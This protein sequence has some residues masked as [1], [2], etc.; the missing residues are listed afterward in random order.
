MD[1]K[2]KRVFVFIKEY[3]PNTDIG[4]VYVAGD[5]NIIDVL[6]G[7]ITSN[8]LLDIST[9]YW[10]S[11]LSSYGFKVHVMDLK[12][13]GCQRI[14]VTY[15]DKS[16]VVHYYAGKYYFNNV[17]TYKWLSTRLYQFYGEFDVSQFD[18]P[19]TAQ[20]RVPVS[21]TRLFDVVWCHMAACDINYITGKR[22]CYPT[23]EAHALSDDHIQVNLKIDSSGTVHINRN[24]ETFFSWIM[25]L[26][27]LDVMELSTE[28]VENPMITIN[29]V[30]EAMKYNNKDF[31]L[32]TQGNDVVE[33]KLTE[34]KAT[35]RFFRL[36]HS[37]SVLVAVTRDRAADTSWI[38]VPVIN[39]FY[40]GKP[41]DDMYV[42]VAS[43]YKSSLN[44]F[45]SETINMVSEYLKK[46]N[47]T[48]DAVLASRLILDLVSQYIS[49]DQAKE[50][51][52]TLEKKLKKLK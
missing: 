10:S 20:G 32:N 7:M 2:L 42:A 5:K 52:N 34:Q 26:S 23:G 16:I 50:I 46:M 15:D 37:R 24:E 28:D 45:G 17:Q 48:G 1:E 18:K 19:A 51:Q 39:G 8:G 27:M 3:T 13:D 30:T 29:D 22:F 33:F 11:D 25:L 35:I 21:Y 6:N 41:S 9:H 43:L 12:A 4:A 40:F 44:V 36:S 31:G 14:L 49:A 38:V 47:P